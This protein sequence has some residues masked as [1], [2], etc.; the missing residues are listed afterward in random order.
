MAWQLGDL[1]PGAAGT[2][3]VTGKPASDLNK[4]VSGSA[5]ATITSQNFDTDSANNTATRALTTTVP[6]AQFSSATY[7][8]G[9]ADGTATL[10]VTLDTANPYADMTLTYAAS[11]DSAQAD[12]DY[13]A[14]S[15]MLT[16]PAGETL[17]T[18]SVPIMNDQL[19]EG[20]E[21]VAVTLSD[22]RG[23]ALAAPSS[24]TLTIVDDDV[25]P[26]ITSAMPPPALAGA[27]Y[28]HQF[29]A[30]GMA[31]PTFSVTSGTLPPGL[32][33]SSDGLLSGIPSQAGVYR[34]ITVTASDSSTFRASVS[35]ASSA[36]QT[37]DIFVNAAGIHVYLPAVMQ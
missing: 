4:D 20:D 7:H 13:N 11:D 37:F 15:G 22:P 5:T 33:L 31:A 36:T 18:F 29:T 34:G 12:S 32:T 28:H 17:A 6:R 27:P 2:I 30:T 19:A 25:A 21:T 14:T 35:V 24:A 23:A 16:I 10:T 26:A 3:T 8:V 9:E 1:A